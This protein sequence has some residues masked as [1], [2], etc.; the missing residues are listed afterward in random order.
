MQNT[1]KDLSI[2]ERRL[3]SDYNQRKEQTLKDPTMRLLGKLI[4]TTQLPL[5]CGTAPRNVKQL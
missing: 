4:P 2:S 1:A 5:V 3:R